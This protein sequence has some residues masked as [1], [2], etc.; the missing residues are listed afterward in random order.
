MRP[1]TTAVISMDKKTRRHLVASVYAGVG[2]T[3]I[4]TRTMNNSVMVMLVLSMTR[5]FLTDIAE[6]YDSNPAKKP[7]MISLNLH[8]I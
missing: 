7:R 1:V 4:R 3:V 5:I 6:H 2:S 8:T